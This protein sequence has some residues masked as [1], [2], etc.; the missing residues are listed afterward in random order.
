MARHVNNYVQRV[1]TILEEE[2]KEDTNRNRIIK[3]DRTVFLPE[4]I[5][6]FIEK[7]KWVKLP[8]VGRIVI[9]NYEDKWYICNLNNKKYLCDLVTEAKIWCENALTIGLIASGKS[10]IATNIKEINIVDSVLGVKE[11]EYQVETLKELFAPQTIYSLGEGF[12]IFYQEDLIRLICLLEIDEKE[13]LTN[14]TREY[15][16]ELLFLESSRSVAELI[17]NICRT[18]DTKLI[19]LQLYR[20]MEYLF[21]VH[22][23]IEMSEKYN[24]DKKVIIKMLCDDNAF[25]QKEEQHVVELISD[26]ADSDKKDEYIKYLQE[27][28]FIGDTVKKENENEKLANYV[29]KRRCQIAHFKYMQEEIKDESVLDKSNERLADLV[30]SMYRKLDNDIVTVNKHFK[31]WSDICYEKMDD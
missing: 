30:C 26:Y 21:M 29:Y 11:E 8:N 5:Y 3:I 31:T 6:K 17:V 16:R 2:V 19:F 20:M 25:W 22:K 1:F 13:Y 12:K 14:K 27:N 28:N 4:K 24:I 10:S 15:L 9:A 23:S 7:M 18:H